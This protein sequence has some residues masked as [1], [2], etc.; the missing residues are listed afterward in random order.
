MKWGEHLKDAHTRGYNAGTVEGAAATVV[1]GGIIY[2]I[3]KFLRDTEPG[4]EIC[5][6]FEEVKEAAERWFRRTFG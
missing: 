5:E 1:V 6:S 3:K 4:Q 2:G